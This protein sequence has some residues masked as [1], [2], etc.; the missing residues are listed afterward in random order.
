MLSLRES[1]HF[2]HCA[3]GLV[4]K[5]APDVIEIADC[6]QNL[7]N[8]VGQPPIFVAW[9]TEFLEQSENLRVNIDAC[10][11]IRAGSVKN[12]SEWALCDCFWIEMLYRPGCCIARIRKERKTCGFALAVQ[13]L[14]AGVVEV[15]F[16]ADF[17]N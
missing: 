3:V 13:L 2:D 8:R 15:S 11:F 5:I 17:D 14:E 1:I 7:V 10:A 16:A 4:R 6:F 9:Q 12:D